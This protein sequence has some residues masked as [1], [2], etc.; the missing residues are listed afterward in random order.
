MDSIKCASNILVGISAAA[1]LAA[2][3]MPQARAANIITIADNPTSCGGATLCSF[4]GTLGYTSTQ[5]FN[6]STIGSW[7]QI[8]VTNPA[9]SYLPGQPPEPNGG[10]GNFLVINNT[11]QIV[12][13]LSF[14]ADGHVL[15]RRHSGKGCAVRERCPHRSSFLSW[16]IIWGHHHEYRNG[17]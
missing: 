2:V 16:A 7:F 15:R 13:S 4:D 11:G 3:S 1:V 12:T 6:L 14:H 17:S 5:P 9:V 8:D 10:A